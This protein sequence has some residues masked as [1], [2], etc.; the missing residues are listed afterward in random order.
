M[1]TQE[2]KDKFKVEDMVRAGL[3][4]K[5]IDLIIMDMIVDYAAK[6]YLEHMEPPKTE[7]L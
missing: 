6:H 3:P 5:L 4:R 7:D 1:M 2:D